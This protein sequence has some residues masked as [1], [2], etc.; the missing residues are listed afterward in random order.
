MHGGIGFFCCKQ[1]WFSLD[2]IVCTL[3]LGYANG[4]VMGGSK[5]WVGVRNCWRVLGGWEG[6]GKRV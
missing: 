1:K 4:G 2:T 5:W 6:V 3:T